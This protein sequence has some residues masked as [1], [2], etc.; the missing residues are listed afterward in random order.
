MPL[1]V[2]RRMKD[3]LL[4]FTRTWYDRYAVE[5]DRVAAASSPSAQ[6]RMV[7]RSAIN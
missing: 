6:D 1:I 5:C 3:V 2:G 7:P 4:E